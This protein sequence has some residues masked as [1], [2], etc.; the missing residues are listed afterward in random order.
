M[1]WSQLHLGYVREFFRLVDKDN[2]GLVSAKEVIRYVRKHGYN[3]TQ[4]QIKKLRELIRKYDTNGD[5]QFN[6]KECVMA[7]C[8]ALPKLRAF[9]QGRKQIDPLSEDKV[10]ELFR[11]I[12]KD[13]NGLISVVDVLLYASEPGLTMKEVNQLLEAIW[14]CDTDGDDQIHIEESLKIDD[15]RAMKDTLKDSLSEDEV[16]E[17]FRKFDRDN[18]GLVSLEEVLSYIS[19]VGVKAT[20]EETNELHENIRKYDT[21]GDGQINFEECLKIDDPTAMEWIRL[22]AQF[23]GRNLKDS[24]SKEVREVFRL[25][26]RDNN[27]LISA[28]EVLSY[29]SEHGV[30]VSEKGANGL[31]S[32]LKKCDTNGDGQLNHEECLKA[33]CRASGSDFSLRAS[34]SDFSD[35]WSVTFPFEE[36]ER[37]FHIHER[38]EAYHASV[39]AQ[40]VTSMMDQ[41]KGLTCSSYQTPCPRVNRCCNYKI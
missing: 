27:D 4:K 34:G 39:L 13:N 15:P 32:V 6:F 7:N 20:E 1:A 33:E 28:E 35:V 38:D 23:Q 25:V 19:E 26:D 17:V 12:D 40:N 30:N 36:I 31:R 5:G 11:L 37:A 2:N 3:P 16:R 22:W 8:H 21:D 29:A 10:R 24:T 9:T 41:K 18:N 14:K